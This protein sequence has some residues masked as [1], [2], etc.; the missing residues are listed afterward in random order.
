MSDNS[1]QKPYLEHNEIAE[2]NTYTPRENVHFSLEPSNIKPFDISLMTG[3]NDS[4]KKGSE[5]K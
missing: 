5:E 1:N 2:I 4:S 3:N